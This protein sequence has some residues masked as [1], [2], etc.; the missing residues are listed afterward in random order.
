[1][2]PDVPDP[3][4]E[5]PGEPCTP[6]NFFGRC[7]GNVLEGCNLIEMEVFRLDCGLFGATCRIQDGIIGCY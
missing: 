4:P 1:M 6:E 3:D 2:N 5:P 7:V